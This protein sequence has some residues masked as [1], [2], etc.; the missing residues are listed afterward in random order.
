MRVLLSI[1]KLTSPFIV[2]LSAVSC[3]NDDSSNSHGAPD[4]GGRP[5]GRGN[6]AQAPEGPIKVP[7][8]NQVGNSL[9]QVRPLIEAD[10]RDQCKNHTLC[11]KV[12]LKEGTFTDFGSKCYSSTAP[13][14]ALPGST[15]YIITGKGA[16][17]CAGAE[18]EVSEQPE[19]PGDGRQPP[20]GLSPPVSAPS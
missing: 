17:P 5:L 13:D 11:V 3:T 7:R 19:S 16:A 18:P 4:A 2:F 20:D 6:G 8:P 9:S 10:I 1:L 14:Y 15:I 12:E